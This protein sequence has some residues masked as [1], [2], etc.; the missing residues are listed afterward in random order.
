MTAEVVPAGVTDLA[1]LIG[2]EPDEIIEA[3]ERR[4]DE[5][6]FPTVGPEVGAWLSVLARTTDADRI[7][8]FGSGF[9]YSAYWFARGMGEGEIVLTEIDA[10][11]LDQARG[12]F[13]QAGIADRA[14]FEHGDA[15]ELIGRYDGPFDIVLID[16]EK[17][18]YREALEAV[19][20]KL[21]RG[22][23]V[24]ADNAVTAGVI[25]RDDV[26]ALLNGHEVQTAT[27]A[28]RGIAEYLD[29]VREHDR[30]ETALLPVGEGVAV[31]VVT[32]S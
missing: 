31:S 11:E 12:Y 25:D 13:E 4:A 28:S 21:R 7:F 26:L 9:G 27:E 3:M 24:L 14:R 16:N 8:E 22:S 10:D 15:I 18:R 2:P 23:L 20:A 32:D 29:Y 5:Q 1:G 19:E 6:N 17:Q 30:L